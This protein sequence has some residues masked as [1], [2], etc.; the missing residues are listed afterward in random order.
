MFRCLRGFSYKNCS[1]ANGNIMETPP[2]HSNNKISS[3]STNH[4]EFDYLL[5]ESPSPQEYLSSQTIATQCSLQNP[6][7]VNTSHLI[8][9]QKPLNRRLNRI[10]NISSVF[11]STKN[12]KKS[13]KF[14]TNENRSKKIIDREQ[15]TTPSP[16]QS[17]LRVSPIKR[18]SSP[19]ERIIGI[20]S[21]ERSH[22]LSCPRASFLPPISL[23]KQ[24]PSLKT[25]LQARVSNIMEAQSLASKRPYNNS[26]RFF[27][28]QNCLVNFLK[29]NKKRNLSYEM[30]VLN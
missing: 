28:W 17:S 24:A 14:S 16:M 3:I 18:S 4:V 20:S 23:K 22:N 9:T 10:K 11:D 2:N 19:L 26:P 8:A 27:D 6:P 12:S 29:K 15:S 30:T 1:I 5:E 7:Q 21:P 25:Q 13:S